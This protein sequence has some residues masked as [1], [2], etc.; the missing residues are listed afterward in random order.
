MG[1]KINLTEQ[2]IKDICDFYIQGKSSIELAKMYNKT[3]SSIGGLLRRRNI[4][5]RSNKQNSRKYSHNEDYFKVIDSEEK[6][7]WL[8]F[9]MADG[10]IT[11]KS[12]QESQRFGITLS[13][14]DI[15]HL[16]KFKKC[17][18]ATNPIKTYQAS[19]SNYNS[20]TLYSRILITSQK[21]V[22]DLKDKGVVE[23]KTNILKFPTEEQVPKE[24]IPHF[25]RGYLD[26]DGCISISNR[27]KRKKIE[28]SIKI[29]GTE[30]FLNGI[31]N[32]IELKTSIK[33]SQYYTRK[34]GQTV[35]ALEFSGNRQVKYFLDLLYQNATIYLDRKHDRYI[36]LCNLYK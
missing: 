36:K 20:N 4:P 13:L 34:V 10:Y 25:I 5:I 26:G 15:N 27:K 16:E 28:Y 29:L 32:F 23:N 22:D 8:G 21:T 3:A 1:R 12:K 31:K 9:I 19:E 33:I 14:K 17:I 30:C 35:K 7:Y 18:Q 2:Q 11:S 24:L 6:A